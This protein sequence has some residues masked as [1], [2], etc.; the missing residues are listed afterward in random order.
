MGADIF[1]KRMVHLSGLV[2]TLLNA[3]LMADDLEP[4]NEPP[5]AVHYG[6]KKK[7]RMEARDQRARESTD[8]FIDGRPFPQHTWPGLPLEELSVAATGLVPELMPSQPSVGDTGEED[9]S[10][11][12]SSELVGNFTRP[13]RSAIAARDRVYSS[14]RVN[15]E[16]RVQQIV[17]SCDA[18]LSTEQQWALNW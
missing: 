10:K 17:K 15:F 9:V 12:L 18:T 14:Q 5:V 16:S 7:M 4:A 13:H 8:P 11:A 3:T 2:I 6:I 1:T